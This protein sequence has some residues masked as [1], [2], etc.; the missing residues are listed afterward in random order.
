MRGL[1][2]T[3]SADRILLAG[4]CSAILLSVLHIAYLLIMYR[5][6]PPLI[7]LFNQLP[8]GEARLAAKTAV[9]LPLAISLIILLINSALA[10]FLYTAMPLVSRILLVTC[11][12]VSTFALIFIVHMTLTII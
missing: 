8:W 11:V 3:I 2:K 4:F 5:H 9:F 6:L 7:P 12:L 1:I 10:R